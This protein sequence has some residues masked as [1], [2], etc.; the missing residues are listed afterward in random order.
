MEKTSILIIAFLFI[1][2]SILKLFGQEDSV[3]I[4][5]TTE[6]VKVS[7]F[8]QKKKYKYFFIVSDFN[9]QFVFIEP[10]THIP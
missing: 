8:N 10:V 5:N 7:D 6:P 9:K 4:E 2:T 3:I 1:N